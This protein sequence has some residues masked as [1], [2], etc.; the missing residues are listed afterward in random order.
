M[1]N[2]LIVK[3]AHCRIKGMQLH[4]T[5]QKILDFISKNG[6]TIED[7][8]LRDLGESIGVG[9]QPQVIAH[10]IDQ[11][12]KK[13]FLRRDPSHKGK[14][15]VLSKP[16]TDVAYINLYGM[17]QCGPEG[18]FGEDCVLDRVPL[19]TKTFG[20]SDP[21]RY[22]LV[23][24]RGES[25]EPMIK[26]GDLVLAAQQDVVD[27]GS[28]AIV[29]HEGMPKIKKVVISAASGSRFYS[30][31]SLNPKFVDENI[32]DESVD[33][34]ILGLVKAVIHTPSRQD[35]KKIIKARRN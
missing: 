11:L 18:F 14:L 33:L 17:A 23:S 27:S 29:L 32:S 15:T 28:I 8:P 2:V 30:L 19:P 12:E 21:S 22:F 4:T 34:R 20:I 24:A 16:I 25:M 7:M 1:D 26:D 10:H 31:V 5:Q 6:G 9:R 35:S 13:G 3:N